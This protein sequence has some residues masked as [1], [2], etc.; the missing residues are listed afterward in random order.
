MKLTLKDIFEV[1]TAEIFNPDEF[2]PVQKVFIDS[3]KVTKNSMFVAIKGKNFDGHD[4]V[5]EAVGKGSSVVVINRRNLKKFDD[6]DIPIV[7]VKNTLTAYGN[8]AAIWRTKLNAKVI[9][10]TGS[11][12]KTTTKEMLST[13]LSERFKVVKSLGNNNNQIGVPLTI[14]SA[15]GKTEILVLEH[16]TNHFG[17][18]EYTAKIAKPDYSMITNIGDSHIQYLKNKHGVYKEKSALFTITEKRGGIVFVNIDDRLLAAKKKMFTNVVSYG[19]KGNPDV[20][21]KIEGFT[22]EGKPEIYINGLGKNVS[23]ILPLLG[24]SNAQNYLAAVAIALK[25]G[26]TKK[27]II[28]GTKKIKPVKG[29]LNLL[30]KNNFAVIDDTYNSNPQSVKEALD[31]LSKLKLFDNKIVILGDMLELGDKSIELHKKLRIP[32]NKIRPSLVLTYGKNMSYL[33]E[34]LLKTKIEAKHFKLRKSLGTFLEKLNINGSI[35]LV[36]GSRGMR[37]EE[38]VEQ[39]LGGTE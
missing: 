22:K 2:K 31:V 4:F 11:N 18:I 29:R 24:N 23:V 12:G 26:L 21:G 36:K 39:L 15:D 25:I 6:L 1:E 38:F 9:S 5:R 35:I 7:T 33:H 13:L 3:R 8:I 14:L 28:N 10:I 37:M 30:V 27:E 17:E 19:F 20:K 16:G 32:L 34:E